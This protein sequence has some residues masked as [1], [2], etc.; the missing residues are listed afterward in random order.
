M[1]QYIISCKNSNKILLPDDRENVKL[2]SCDKLVYSFFLQSVVYIAVFLHRALFSCNTSLWPG[3][4]G[5][6]VFEIERFFTHTNE[7]HN[8]LL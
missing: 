1:F 2:K 3:V 8:N 5:R 6:M 7:R 4:C